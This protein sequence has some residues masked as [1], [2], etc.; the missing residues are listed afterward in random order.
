MQISAGTNVAGAYGVAIQKKVNA[1]AEEQGKA[2]VELI[3]QS[4]A[5]GTQNGAAVSPTPGVG[6]RVNITA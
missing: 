2:A 1:T 5:S 4:T 6:T 3:Q